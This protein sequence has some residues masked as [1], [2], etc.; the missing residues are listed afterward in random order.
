MTPDSL[1]G[2]RPG[3]STR[4]FIAGIAGR[5]RVARSARSAERT[6]R[7]GCRAFIATTVRQMFALRFSPCVQVSVAAAVNRILRE[8][9]ASAADT[10]RDTAWPAATIGALR[11]EALTTRLLQRELRLSSV[12]VRASSRVL[13]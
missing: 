12:D 7:F 3:H 6:L 2:A 4:A 8:P 1:R 9:N 13:R 11:H 5:H 10:R